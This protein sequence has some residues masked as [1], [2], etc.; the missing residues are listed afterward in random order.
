MMDKYWNIHLS[1]SWSEHNNPVTIR[2]VAQ[3]FCDITTLLMEYDP[4]KFSNRTLWP[5]PKNTII[6]DKSD[7]IAD[8]IAHYLLAEHKQD[9]RTQVKIQN[10]NINY[11]GR[12]EGY[13]LS[14]RA[15]KGIEPLDVSFWLGGN[16]GDKVNMLFAIKIPDNVEWYEKLLKKLIT[17]LAPN[18]A[19]IYSDEF[20]WTTRSKDF[21]SC[22]CGWINYFDQSFNIPQPDFEVATFEVFN[23]GIYIKTIDE[24]FDY[25]NSKH[26]EIG[27]QEVEFLREC[28]IIKP[29]TY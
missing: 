13:G 21:Y 5:S 4:E 12:W 20:V 19:S 15:H 22:Y 9:I 3:T 25:E 2:E 8:T 28:N 14:L 17:E 10:P 6:K 29:K 16:H 26:V 27:K 24:V 1:L 7:L 23:N 18:H 11:D